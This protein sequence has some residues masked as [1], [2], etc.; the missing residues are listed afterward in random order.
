MDM[1]LHLVA[2]LKCCQN[3]VD[4]MIHLRN[5]RFLPDRTEPSCARLRRRHGSVL[6][7][8]RLRLVEELVN[9]G[10]HLHQ[11]GRSECPDGPI[12]HKL[13]LPTSTNDQI[14]AQQLY[15]P[16]HTKL[17]SLLGFWGPKS[18]WVWASRGSRPH[19]WAC[20]RCQDVRA[21]HNHLL[22]TSTA[23]PPK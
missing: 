10:S 19:L 12:T 20:I 7:C 8:L 22:P 9:M 3:Q 5:N 14:S 21:V 23:F 15:E 13:L 6:P 17:P 11:P 1:S 4:R 16:F 2:W 18:F